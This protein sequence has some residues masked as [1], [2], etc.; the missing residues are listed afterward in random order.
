MNVIGTWIIKEVLK[1]TEDFQR[2]WTDVETV[3]ANPETDESDK[4]MLRSKVVFGEDGFIHMVMPIPE[5]ISQQEVDEAVASGELKRF[6]NNLIEYEQ[7]EW[8]EE[9]G[10]TMFNTGIKGEVLGE[11]IS[12]W[13]KIEEQD[14]FLRFFTY[15][16]VK[17]DD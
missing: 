12:P 3:L 1:F 13:D 2:V 9:N 4:R 17:E 14:G 11:K 16:L 7:Y 10:Q 5:G 8:K 15:H 6:G